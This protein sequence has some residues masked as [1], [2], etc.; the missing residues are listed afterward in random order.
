M[1][2]PFANDDERASRGRAVGGSPGKWNGTGPE[3][4]KWHQLSVPGA[5]KLDHLQPFRPILFWNFSNFFTFILGNQFLLPQR[6]NNGK[7]G[8]LPTSNIGDCGGFQCL[9]HSNWTHCSPLSPFCSE[10]FPTFSPSYWGANS[11]YPRRLIMG[12]RKISPFPIWMRL[13]GFSA[14]G[15]QTGPLAAL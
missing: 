8:I 5:F 3:I 14:W 9:G 11:Y 4:H 12:V 13:R 7:R 2:D 15:I 10:N 1:G 6:A